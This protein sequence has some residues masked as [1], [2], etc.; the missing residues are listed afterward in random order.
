MGFV[1]VA[2]NKIKNQKPRKTAIQ[3]Q[4]KSTI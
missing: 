3:L 2:K 4:F 1:A